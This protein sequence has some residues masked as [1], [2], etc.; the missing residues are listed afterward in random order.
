MSDSLIGDSLKGMGDGEEQKGRREEGI[1]EALCRRM[2]DGQGSL[3]LQGLHG[4]GMKGVKRLEPAMERPSVPSNGQSGS[5]HP[6]EGAPA[7]WRSAGP[8][9]AHAP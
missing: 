9:L 8:P 6:D 3:H 2:T 5:A 4:K 1:Q 7:T